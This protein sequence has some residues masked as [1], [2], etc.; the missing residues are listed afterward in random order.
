MKASLTHV[1]WTLIVKVLY[2]GSLHWSFYSYAIHSFLLKWYLLMV[3]VPVDRR[4][5]CN[6][7]LR[8][9]LNYFWRFERDVNFE[10]HERILQYFE[11]EKALVLTLRNPYNAI[12][13]DR[14]WE[15]LINDPT[16]DD[17]LSKLLN[18]NGRTEI[19]QQRSDPSDKRTPWE[20]IAVVM[21]H[22][23]QYPTATNM[24]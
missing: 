4:C 12:E 19:R 21:H 13:K 10:L 22:N 16:I 5:Q 14:S 3:E 7:L 15:E 9:F 20:Q 17:S 24:D 23:I 6:V 18:L 1:R 2:P 8:F 11:V